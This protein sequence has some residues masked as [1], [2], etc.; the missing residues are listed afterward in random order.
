MVLKF[1]TNQAFSFFKILTHKMLNKTCVLKIFLKIKIER[2]IL[3]YPFIHISL[4]FVLTL[5]K[6][7]WD[8]WPTPLTKTKFSRVNYST[9]IY[10]Y[11]LM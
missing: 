2:D 4:R 11:N 3:W 9:D 8:H 5:E 7:I 10:Q 1:S 6:G